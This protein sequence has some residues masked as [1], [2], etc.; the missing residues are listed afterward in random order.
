MWKNKYVHVRAGMAQANFERSAPTVRHQERIVAAPFPIE[1]ER[2]PAP[3]SAWCVGCNP[4][5]CP[6]CKTTQK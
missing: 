4:M 6:G 3:N 1:P 5:N 2:Q